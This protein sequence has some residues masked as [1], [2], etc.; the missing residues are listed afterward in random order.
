MAPMVVVMAVMV[1]PIAVTIAMVVAPSPDAV[2]AAMPVAM[3]PPAAP[4]G[5][6]LDQG[7]GGGRHARRGGRWRSRCGRRQQASRQRECG[8]GNKFQQHQRLLSL[9]RRDWRGNVSRGAGVPETGAQRTTAARGARQRAAASCRCIA[10]DRAG[11]WRAPRHSARVVNVVRFSRRPRRAQV[12]QP[13]RAG[14][15]RIGITSRQQTTSRPKRDSCSA[16]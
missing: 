12:G 5:R 1:A 4:P 9:N 2:P 6:L 11:R 16:Q 14:S 3:V 13:T 10:K 15:L 8:Q 7:R